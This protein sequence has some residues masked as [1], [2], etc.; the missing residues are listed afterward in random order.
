MCVDTLKKPPIPD[1]YALNEKGT[2][3]YRFLFDSI[4]VLSIPDQFCDY[5]KDI[6]STCSKFSYPNLFEW[7]DPRRHISPE[8]HIDFIFDT[9]MWNSSSE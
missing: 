4:D 9:V 1:G 2:T 7:L 3:E 6:H 5:P 8:H